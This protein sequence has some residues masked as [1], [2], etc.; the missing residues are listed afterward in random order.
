MSGVYVIRNWQTLFETNETRK[1]KTLNWWPHPNKHDGL[2]FRKMAA[3]PNAVELYCAWNLICD[4]ASKTTPAN[5]RGY[6]ERDNLPLSAG[7]MGCCAGFPA[8][9][10]ERALEFFSSDSIGW[11]CKES[12]GTPADSPDASGKLPAEGKGREGTERRNGSPRPVD[13]PE[14]FPATESE[15]VEQGNFLGCGRDFSLKVW[16]LAM[17]RH[18]HDSKGQPIMSFRHHLQTQLSY[19]NE[20]TAKSSQPARRRNIQNI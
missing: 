16:N 20:R 13:L 3:Q 2:G 7:D 17:S 9:V 8:D 1:L 6:L 10:F 11:L 19:E 4:L 15:A 5:R 18:G 14:G 12:P